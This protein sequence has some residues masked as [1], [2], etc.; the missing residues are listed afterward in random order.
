[1]AT[2]LLDQGS[3]AYAGGVFNVLEHHEMFGRFEASLGS[4][5]RMWWA[6][7]SPDWIASVSVTGTPFYNRLVPGGLDQVPGLN[8]RLADG[9]VIVDSACGVGVGLI[10]LA[11]RYPGARLVGVDGDAHSIDVARAR[12]AAAWPTGC[13]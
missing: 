7:T 12:I 9:G 8:E 4:G 13:G 6:D 10:R 2:L 5:E 3:P 11:A 1:M